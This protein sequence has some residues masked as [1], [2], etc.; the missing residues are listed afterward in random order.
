MAS[1]S[2]VPSSSSSNGSVA[3]TVPSATISETPVLPSPRPANV[4]IPTPIEAPATPKQPDPSTPVFRV[5]P[6]IVYLDVVVRDRNNHIVHG[7]TKDEFRIFEDGHAQ[8]IDSFRSV[9]EMATTNVSSLMSRPLSAN[10]SATVAPSETVNVILF[11]LLDT[12]PVDQTYARTQMLKF[13]RALPAGQRIGLFVLT[14]H[15]L[16]RIQDFTEDSAMLT[17]AAQSFFRNLRPCFNPTIRN[18]TVT[19]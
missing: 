14:S 6:G 18:G 17:E 10:A 15:E 12:S 13:L 1:I 16:R 5:T 7:L 9:N 3:S 4:P 19:M 2:N 11:D 8:T